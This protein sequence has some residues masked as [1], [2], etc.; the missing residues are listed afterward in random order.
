MTLEHYHSI[1]QDKVDE[2]HEVAQQARSKGLDPSTEVEIEQAEDLAERCEKLIGVE[3]LKEKIRDMEDQEMEREDIAFKLA[4][5]FAKGEIGDFETD[6]EKIDAAVRTAIA[7]L[8]EG[9]VAAPIDGIGDIELQKND[10]GTT[11][12]RVP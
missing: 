6:D 2:A 4:E 5:D 9:V 8:T 1:I 12:I 10:D 11:F 3:G 7:L